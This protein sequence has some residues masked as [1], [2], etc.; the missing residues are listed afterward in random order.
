M[1]RNTARES[2][3]VGNFERLNRLQEY[4]PAPNEVGIFQPAPAKPLPLREAPWY[5]EF[6]FVKSEWIGCGKD[7]DDMKMTAQAK[8]RRANA[9]RGK[10]LR[11]VILRDDIALVCRAEDPVD[12]RFYIYITNTGTTRANAMTEV[13]PKDAFHIMFGKD[14]KISEPTDAM[15]KLVWVKNRAP[16]PTSGPEFVPIYS[17]RL[18]RYMSENLA[19][20]PVYRDY[21]SSM[22]MAGATCPLDGHATRIRNERAAA[23]SKQRASSNQA[24]S[25]TLGLPEEITAPILPKILPPP[26][27]C[28]ADDGIIA[29]PHNSSNPSN[30]SNPPNKKRPEPEPASAPRSS[31]LPS[32]SSVPNPPNQSNSSSLGADAKKQRV[33]RRQPMFRHIIDALVEKT[34]QD[35]YAQNE[36]DFQ[37][38]ERDEAEGAMRLFTREAARSEEHTELRAK[39]MVAVWRAFEELH[40]SIVDLLPSEPP[41]ETTY[42]DE[43]PLHVHI[44]D[45]LCESLAKSG[46][47]A[48]DAQVRKLEAQI[49]EF[50]KPIEEHAVDETIHAHMIIAIWRSFERLYNIYRPPKKAIVFGSLLDI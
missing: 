6:A 13:S 36:L 22:R 34:R 25:L 49:P 39:L 50:V 35:G 40:N 42:L 10:P 31:N 2:L 20:L 37:D 16:N 46:Y 5:H 29:E 27:I 43:K 33:P 14:A 4:G 21:V 48:L 38:V 24:M 28:I 47:A 18:Y 11:D 23:R 19:N 1:N 3:V 7:F 30:Q 41:I 26:Y 45:R 8:S 44:I 12:K 15:M 17:D 32:S 9:P